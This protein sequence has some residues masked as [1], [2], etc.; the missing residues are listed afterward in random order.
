MPLVH[1]AHEIRMRHA[2]VLEDE[3]RVLVEAPAALVEDL[4]DAHTRRVDR[5][6]ERRAAFLLPHIGIGARIHEEEARDRA[7]RNKAF[8][9]IENP[10]VALAFG[11]QSPAGFGIL[12]GRQPVIGAGVGLGARLPQEK[13]VVGDERPQEALLLFVVALGHDEMAPLPALA[14]SLR[15]RHVAA[16]EL[17]HHDRLC[18][19]VDAVTAPFRRDHRGSETEPRAFPDHVPVERLASIGDAVARERDGPKRLLREGPRF[20]L[21]LLLLVRECEV[22]PILSSSAVAG[23]PITS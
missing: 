15:D 4:S 17:R 9:A 6:E 21:P 5:D 13:R 22:H 23:V 18:H 14:E 20:L 16:R 3:L 11:A 10:F 1:F 8:L 12:F 7:V 2:R 19:E